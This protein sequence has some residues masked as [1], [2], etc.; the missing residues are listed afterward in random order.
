MPRKPKT[1]TK[2]TS[3][4]KSSNSGGNFY[5]DFKNTAQKMAWAAFQQH[6]VLFLLGPAGVG[7]SYLSCAFAIEQVLAKQKKKIVLTRPIVEAGE[8]LGYLPGE[9][10]DKVHPYMMPM[11]DCIDRLVSGPKNELINERVELAPIAYMRGRAII[12]SEKIITPY[13]LKPMGEIRVGDYVIGKN[14][15]ATRVQAVYPQGEV[16]VFEIKFSDGTKSV[17]CENHLWDTMTLNE[18]RHNKGYTTK[19]TKD[20][21]ENVKNK[22]NQKV[23]RVPIADPVSFEKQNVPI[24][25]Y[26]MGVLLGDGHVSYPA[27]SITTCDQE[28]ADEVARLLPEN[29]DLVYRGKYD[30]RVTS[31][32]KQNF[33]K[34]YFKE[35]GLCG[36]K[37]YEKFVPDNYK[38]NSIECRTALLQGLLDSNG[39]IC[40][41]RSGNCRIQFCSTSH[42]LA[43]DVMF[44]VRS[45][46]GMSYYRKREYDEDDSHEYNGRVV[47]HAR[48]SYIVDIMININPFRLTRKSEQFEPNQKM[49]KMISSIE[50]KGTAKATC[51]TV[52]A[53]D[54]LFLTNDFIVTHN[55]F[56][57]SVCIFDEA[58]NASYMQ[59]KLFLT[60]FGENSKVI[61][62][63]DPNQSDLP[64][65]K[66]DLME[67]VNK[68]RGVE[69]IGIVEFGSDS[70]VRHSL[71]SKIVD[72]LE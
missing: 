35:I 5:I 66:V 48:P 62:T 8:T 69:G 9:F 63:G 51:I 70:I 24:D 40:K 43:K 11:Y 36:L 55:T 42:K 56:H 18:K 58:Q 3:S 47:R 71:V 15:K 7:K 1:P 27:V 12:D 46:G 31:N 64:G 44:L 23:H 32:R 28:I 20:I 67:V 30:Y 6:D 16:P 59:L 61:V 68:L 57:D 2:S 65:N 34:S 17:C 25:P 50:P 52:D 10:Q 37:S 33:I 26:L 13:G 29:H 38:F 14:G 49:T 54:G 41:H 21:M 60:R 45:L 39:W 53:N 72:K 22:H 19:K 4:G